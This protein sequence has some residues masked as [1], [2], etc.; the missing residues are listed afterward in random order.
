MKQTRDLDAPLLLGI[1][2][3]TSAVKVSVARVDGTVVGNGTASYPVIRPR[4][5]RAEQEPEDWWTA[6]REAVAAALRMA[7]GAGGSLA[8]ADRIAVIG[9][10]GQMHGTVLIGSARRPLGRAIIWQDQRSGDEAARVAQAFGPRRLIEMIGTP[11]ASGFQAAT[12]AWLREHD[13]DGWKRIRLVLAPKDAVRLRMTGEIGTDPSDASGTGLV[14]IRSADWAAPL[15]DVLGVSAAWMPPIR[16]AASIAG[17]LTAA[18]AADLGLR[19][20]TPVTVGGAD[21]PVGLLGAG[22]LTPDSCLLTLSTGGQLALPTASL[23]IDPLGRTHTFSTPLRGTA[24]VT[25]WYRLA[26]TLSA[27]A[28]LQWLRDGILVVGGDDAYGQM[29]RWATDVPAGARGLV[30]LPYLTG[31]R[32][33]HMDPAARGMFLGLTAR[34]GRAELIRA[35]LEGVAFAAYDAARVLGERSRLPDTLVLAG[36]GGK[37]PLWRGIIADV[38]GLPV[39]RLEVAEQAAVGACI[40]AGHAAGLLDGVNAARAWAQYGPP[41]I[42]DPARQQRYLELFAI[43]R[44]AYQANRA[45]FTALAAFDGPGDA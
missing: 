37:S 4:P 15:L 27:G 33:P 10:S 34:H 19:T 44:E 40:I 26:A 31:E 42:P 29:N 28:A 43:Y 20:G 18:A 36:G 2:L 12:L 17:G 30:F 45:S 35:L 6:I 7:A 23:E 38:F 13:P 24:E 9:L 1:D 39:R 5:D 25:D 14:D 21:T 16:S 22:V 11:L 32:T 41:A 3:G 8:I